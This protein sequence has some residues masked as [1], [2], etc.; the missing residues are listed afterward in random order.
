MKMKNYINDI[1]NLSAS[2]KK[3]KYCKK[4]NGRIRFLNRLLNV[5]KIKRN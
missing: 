2:F 5:R 3:K 4:I 1:L